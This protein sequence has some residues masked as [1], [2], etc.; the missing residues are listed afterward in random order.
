MTK[1]IVVTGASGNVGT[2]LLRLYR[3][4]V[5]GTTALMSSWK[6]CEGGTSSLPI[7]E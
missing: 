3:V 7:A 6:R 4:G 5:G 2:A 1:R